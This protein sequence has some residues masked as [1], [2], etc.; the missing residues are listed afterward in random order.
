MTHTLDLDEGE[1]QALLMALA[2]LAVERQGW[3]D[4]LNRVAVRIDNV[5]DG[6]AAM[7]D[8]FRSLRRHE[9]VDTDELAFDCPRCGARMAVT[10]VD[11]KADIFHLKPECP[12]FVARERDYRDEV[13]QLDAMKRQAVRRSGR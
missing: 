8:E 13:L 1:R 10:W 4:M 2:H 9:I 7:Y 12:A 6:R 11:G 3:D 5:L